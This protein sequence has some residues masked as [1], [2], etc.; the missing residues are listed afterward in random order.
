MNVFHHPQNHSSLSHPTR[1]PITQ[2]AHLLL[3]QLDL[4]HM[5]MLSQTQTQQGATLTGQRQVP[6]AEVVRLPT[7]PQTPITGYQR[8]YPQTTTPLT[9][10]TLFPL[11]PTV[12]QTVLRRRT[13]PIMRMV[14]EVPA[15]VMAD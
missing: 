4:P 15:M 11:L 14:L 13:I 5:P 9:I 12:E 7:I 6:N 8:L 1:T 10:P 2:T 3:V